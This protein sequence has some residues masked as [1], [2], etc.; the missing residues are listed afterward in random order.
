MEAQEQTRLTNAINAIIDAL[1][2]RYLEMT[3]KNEKIQAVAEITKQLLPLLKKEYAEEIV[4]KNRLAYWNEYEG[5]AY[6]WISYHELNETE[7]LEELRKFL[8]SRLEI[9]IST[10]PTQVSSG[11]FL[12]QMGFKRE[13]DEN[14]IYYTKTLEINGVKVKVLFERPKND[15]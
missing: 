2:E 15:P 10:E 12:T 9:S 3:R 1:Y 5:R 6:H 11:E 7:K 8:G 4:K 13:E 14:T